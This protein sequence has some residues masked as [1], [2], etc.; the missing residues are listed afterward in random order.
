MPLQLISRF[1]ESEEWLPNARQRNALKVLDDAGGE[2]YLRALA[3]RVAEIEHQ[4]RNQVFSADIIDSPATTDISTRCRGSSKWRSVMTANWGHDRPS[5]SDNMS[6]DT[7]E[8]SRPLAETFL[9]ISGLGLITIYGASL[10]IW[11]FPL[12]PPRIWSVLFLCLILSVAG[13]E[14]MKRRE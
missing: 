1:A 13:H 9:G 3:A 7:L 6:D 10:G 14:S 11:K 8:S 12:L 4:E 5:P 2:L